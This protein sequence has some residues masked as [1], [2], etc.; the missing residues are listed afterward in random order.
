[1]RTAARRN[2]CIVS[3]H[4]SRTKVVE[5]SEVDLE[6]VQRLVTEGENPWWQK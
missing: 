4:T 1:M 6:T 2:V 3:G 5:V